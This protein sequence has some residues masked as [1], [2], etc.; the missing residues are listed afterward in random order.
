MSTATANTTS[1]SRPARRSITAA[2]LVNGAILT[3]D[4]SELQ[5]PYTDEFTTSVDRELAGG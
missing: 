3:L 5:P 1:A 4:R 2:V